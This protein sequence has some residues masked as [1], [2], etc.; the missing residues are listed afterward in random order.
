[1]TLT[2]QAAA[3]NVTVIE[4]DDVKTVPAGTTTCRVRPP[5]TFFNTRN[6]PSDE[7]GNSR[8]DV[9]PVSPLLTSP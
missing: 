6:D 4:L 1:M 7:S 9:M 8:A 5:P 2:N 3:G